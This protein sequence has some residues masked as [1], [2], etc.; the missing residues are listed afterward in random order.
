M[1]YLTLLESTWY[2]QI[3]V[4][5]I[6][7]SGLI[8]FLKNN[9][10]YDA[11]SLFLMMAVI[12]TG[13]LPY[14]EAL[15][16]F[17]HPTIIIVGA[18][19]V[20]TSALVQ[21]GIIDSIVSRA[22]FLYH[23]PLV[24]LT[25]LII[26]VTTISAFVNN[27]GALA[28]VMPIAL[29]LAQKG[30]TSVAYFLLPLAF[31]SHLGGYLTLIGTPRN[32]LISDFRAEAVGTPFSMFDFT[33][34]GGGIAITG[35]LFLISYAW[36]FLPRRPKATGNES[37]REYTT[38]VYVPSTAKII[39]LDIDKFEQKTKR[40]VIVSTI[41]R[42]GVPL[43][44]TRDTLIHEEDVLCL[45]GTE[46][47]LTQVTEK[48][49]LQL[50]G[51]RA[52]ERYITTSD[53]YMSTEA[54]IPPYAKLIGRS[55]DDIP[56]R[57]RFGTNFIGVHRYNFIPQ[58][59][60]AKT[61]LQ[62]NDIILLQGRRESVE[63]TIAALELLPL[64]N[65]DVKLGRT[66]TI[67][68]TLTVL[69]IA[70]TLATM[71]VAPIAL[72]F[73]TTVIVLVGTNLISLR[74]AYDSVDWPILVLL[75]GMITLGDALVAS[76]AAETIASSIVSLSQLTSPYVILVV[77]LATSMLMSDFIN[78]TASAVIMSPIA[79]MIATSMNVS[80]DPFLMAVAVGASSAF[81]TPVG[82]ESNALVMQ[83]GGYRFSDF[84][85]M[86]LPLELLIIIVSIPLIVYAW[87]LYIGA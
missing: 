48:F 43:R 7:A 37:V 20:M 26:L 30:T 6:L 38:E 71:Q 77:I 54:V 22:S 52:L 68:A 64:A 69:G 66:T 55:W 78:T 58:T 67:V 63:S 42:N 56:L 86:G 81:L 61:K 13:I 84:T 18:M 29:Y 27:V 75:A 31:A 10:R 11:V 21:C 53:E 46:E 36:F 79:I 80:I 44:F 15:A 87:P 73:L 35:I 17:G 65:S 45:Q 76:G 49:K 28:I 50:T 2:Q 1:D 33:M 72:I 32:I 51:L 62:T 40:Q 41:L 9:L 5:V 59:F 4:L 57:I 34:V 14:D 19:F 12:I 85:R 8:L 74:A 70:I 16:N 47:A 25:L 39:H 24:S 60:L 23:R 82:H 3:V 83:K